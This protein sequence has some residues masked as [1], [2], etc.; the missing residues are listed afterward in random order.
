MKKNNNKIR[1]FIKKIT[2]CILIILTGINTVYATTGPDSLTMTNHDF[3]NTGVQFPITF[4][5]K[6]T[7][8]G[9]YVYCMTFTKSVPTGV[10]YSRK[11]EYTDPGMNYI[12]Q[13]GSKVTNDNDYFIYQTALWIYMID[14]GLMVNANELNTFRA[15]LANTNNSTKNKINEVVNKAKNTTTYEKEN[16]P[17]ISINDK[18]TFTKKDNYYISNEINIKSSEANYKVELQNAPKDTTYENNNNKVII[19]VPASSVT[20]TTEITLKVSNSKTTYKSYRYTPNDAKYQ[21]MSATYSET[22]TSNAE[23][24]GK[25]TIIPTKKVVISKQDITNKEELPGA[26]LEVKDEKNNIIESWISEEKPHE[27]YLKPGKYTLTETQAP[28]GYILSKETIS[29]EVKENNT[30][31][32]KVVM[33]NTKKEVPKKP[34]PEPEKPKEEIVVP[35]TGTKRTIT[36]SII[37]SILLIIGSIFITRNVK[38]KNEQ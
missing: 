12:L 38:N 7:S 25:I 33:Y 8:D 20:A 13:E 19:K 5:V 37:G 29:F 23:E 18:I 17:T 15:T 22:K 14:K 35:S 16:N 32:T 2:T 27:I 21:D 36:S 11:E 31:T 24:K 28:E 4:H 3:N 26:K 6:T 34:E 10:A 9:K 1:N 30:T